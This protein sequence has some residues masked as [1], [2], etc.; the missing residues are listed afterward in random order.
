MVAIVEKIMFRFGSRFQQ[1]YTQ[2]RCRLESFIGA[3]DAEDETQQS[4]RA[5]CLI[6]LMLFFSL[7]FLSPDKIPQILAPVQLDFEILGKVQCVLRAVRK[8]MPI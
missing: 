4:A 7:V 1:L 3:T 2:I 6:S 8:L 5:F